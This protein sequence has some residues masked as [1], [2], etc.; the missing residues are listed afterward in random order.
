MVCSKVTNLSFHASL[1]Q[2]QYWHDPL[3]EDDYKQK[4]IF[5][6]EINNELVC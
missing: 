1:I 2:A 5:L 4:S 3:H 6:A